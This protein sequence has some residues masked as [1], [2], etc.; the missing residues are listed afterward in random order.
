MT[1]LKP[2]RSALVSVYHKD[3][4]APLIGYLHQQGVVLYATG[5]TRDFIHEL[6]I[7]VVA[8]ESVTDYP[9]ILG[10]R[11]KTLHPKVFGGILGR[12]GHDDDVAQLETY[13][14]PPIDLVVVDLYPFEAT[15]KAGASA[16]DI[17]EKIDIGGI[18]LIRAAAKNHKDVV[19]VPSMADYGLLLQEMQANS[20]STSL[21]YRKIQATKA[22]H[23]SS[24]YDAAIAGWLSGRE[25]EVFSCSIPEA[26]NLRYGENPHQKGVFYG[27]L[28]DCFSQLSGKD[29]SYNNLLDIDAALSLMNEFDTPVT[30]ILKHNNACGVATGF[31][32]VEN[33]ER[34]LAS[35]P[36]SAFGGVIVTSS[37]VDERLADTI[38]NLFFEV[39]IAPAYSDAALRRLMEKKNRILLRLVDSSMSHAQFR[40]ILNGVLWQERDSKTATAAD[41]KTVTLLKPS[42][43]EIRDLL[44]ANKIV[45]HSRSN[46]IVLAK[47][48]RLISAGVGQTSRVDALL[49]AIEKAGKFSISLEGAVMASDAFFPFPD[50]VEIARKSG[51][52]AVIQPGGSVKDQDSINYCNAHEMSMVFTGIRHFR[53]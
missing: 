21:K 25:T 34:A 26:R 16:D 35:D 40:T 37:E 31:T 10:G 4:L 33:W 29:L 43:R 42:D 15:R 48:N 49:Q 19:I 50:C 13:Q 20:G 45:K 1:D 47:D 22:F 8:V 5:G 27:R 41:L 28:E 53:H 2:I 7:P 39:L 38:G 52:R 12:R 46:T 14:I 36:V 30:A 11:V 3:G 18:S 44:F 9:S 6:K 24:G 51:I 17:I 23:L 32:P